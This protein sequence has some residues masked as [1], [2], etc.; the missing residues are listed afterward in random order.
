MVLP[1]VSI[2]IHKCTGEILPETNETQ[3]RIGGRVEENENMSETSYGEHNDR[4]MNQG[5]AQYLRCMGFE[6]MD[7][8][9]MNCPYRATSDSEAFIVNG[10][11]FYDHARGEGGNVWTL[12]LALN[13]GDKKAALE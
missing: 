12:A 5:C 6:A 1:T 8:E 2:H 3:R 13:G 10:P 4:I 7:G 9:G 11:L